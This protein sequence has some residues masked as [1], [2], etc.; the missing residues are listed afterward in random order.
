MKITLKDKEYEFD[1]E[2]AIETGILKPLFIVKAGDVW[3]HQDV[4]PL[5]VVQVIYGEDPKD[6][7]KFFT[8]VGQ[9]G[10][11]PFANNSEGNALRSIDDIRTYFRSRG[12]WF[13]RNINDEVIR[14]I[15]K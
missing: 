3:T 1:V 15:R 6:T 9:K 2:K 8:L 12:M 7:D 13:V 11:T 10:L 14:L 5:L 4:F